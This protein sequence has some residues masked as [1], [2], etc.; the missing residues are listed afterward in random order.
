M[1]QGGDPSS[2]GTGGESIYPEGNFVDEFHSRLKFN[3]RGMVAMA[4][5]GT[6]NKNGS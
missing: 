1:V 3:R 2:T 4:N 6:P 5:D